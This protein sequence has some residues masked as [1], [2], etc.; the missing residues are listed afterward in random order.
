M[1]FA[2]LALLLVFGSTWNFIQGRSPMELFTRAAPAAPRID[3]AERQRLIGEQTASYCQAQVAEAAL[4][5]ASEV[6]LCPRLLE[7]SGSRYRAGM[8]YQ[9][10]SRRLEVNISTLHPVTVPH[11]WSDSLGSA[12]E[13]PTFRFAKEQGNQK[14]EISGFELSEARRVLFL[15]RFVAVGEA[16][17]EEAG[18]LSRL[19]DAALVATSGN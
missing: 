4:E 19:E 18:R 8:S 11:D 1:P 7:T 12:L 14:I 3:A 13:E 15:H 17:L 2:V 10:P 6:H 16:C 5:L 9:G